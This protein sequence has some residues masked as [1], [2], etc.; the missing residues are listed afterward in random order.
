M[1]ADHINPRHSGW[2]TIDENCQMLCKPCNRIKS[3]I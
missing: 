2:K 1:E 3:G